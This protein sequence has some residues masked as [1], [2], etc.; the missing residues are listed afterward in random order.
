MWKIILSTFHI[1]TPFSTADLIWTPVPVT[2]SFVKLIEPVLDH[3]HSLDFKLPNVKDNGRD[4]RNQSRFNSDSKTETYRLRIRFIR[5][6]ATGSSSSIKI[7]RDNFS[8]VVAG[9]VT[10][11]TS[12]HSRKKVR[13]LKLL[14]DIRK[15]SQLKTM[16][17]KFEEKVK[18]YGPNS[19]G[20]GFV[21]AQACIMPTLKA[22]CF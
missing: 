13:L 6:A 2:N 21:K 7:A 15:Y 17:N 22:F 12:F 9:S 20:N 8:I 14:M 5:L 18:V 11:L 4:S 3:L 19:D 10:D 16:Q 1:H